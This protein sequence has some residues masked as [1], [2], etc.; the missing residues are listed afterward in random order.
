MA[1]CK[2]QIFYPEKK[3][4]AYYRKNVEKSLFTSIVAVGDIMI[5]EH[6]TY[7]LDKYSIDYPFDSTCHIL[8][9]GHFTIGNLESPFSTTGTKYDK[10]FTFKI[11]PKYAPSLINA[12][13]DVVT[14]AN[15]HIR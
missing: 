1:I 12:G 7:Y 5:G 3:T 2:P 6:V 14:L 15:N 4:N 13:F 10:R 11:N 8:N 9:D